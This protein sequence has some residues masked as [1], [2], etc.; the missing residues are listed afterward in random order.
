MMALPPFGGIVHD[1]G[2]GARADLAAG[3]GV[4]NVAVADG[5]QGD[6]AD[7]DVVGLCGA[8]AVGAEF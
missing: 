8:G 5:Q 6:V 1:G 3:G 7:V 4:V 2:F